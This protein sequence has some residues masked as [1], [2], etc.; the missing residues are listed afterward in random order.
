MFKNSNKNVK[1]VGNVIFFPSVD[2]FL[3]PVFLQLGSLPQPLLLSLHLYFV[4]NV[5]VL[6]K[7]LR[8]LNTNI[9][10]SVTFRLSI[11]FSNTQPY[12]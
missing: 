12:S 5:C 10:I 11:V 2:K 1:S 3:M 9:E 7:L 4:Q 8:M 6:L